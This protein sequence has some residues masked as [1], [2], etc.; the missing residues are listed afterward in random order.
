MGK[1]IAIE[2][3]GFLMES[4]KVFLCLSTLVGLRTRKRIIRILPIVLGVQ[5]IIL[6][7]FKLDNAPSNV[8]M[9]VHIILI[10]ILMLMCFRARFR[11]IIGIYI[12]CQAGISIMDVLI[13]LFIVRLPGLSADELLGDKVII[14]MIN[15]VSLMIILI[16]AMIQRRINKLILIPLKE[17]HWSYYLLIIWVLFFFTLMIGYLQLILEEDNNTLTN[18][19]LLV[20]SVVTFGII[21]I[22]IIMSR[23]AYNR[24][25][26][27]YL[28]KMNEE[29]LDIQQQYYLLL[30]QKNEDIKRF[31]HDIKNHFLCLRSITQEGDMTKVISYLNDLIPEIRDITEKVSTGSNVADAII[32]D[33]MTKY[34][35]VT[36]DVRGKLPNPLFIHAVDICT[37]FSNAIN[38]ALEAVLKFPAHADK[39]ISVQIKNW[40]NNIYITILNPVMKKPLIINNEIETTKPERSLHGFG[41]SNIKRCVAKYH[42]TIGLSS[43]DTEF[44]LELILKNENN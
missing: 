38:N 25:K 34:P 33:A 24:D 31:R 15:S 3:V 40:E 20:L 43:T 30:S 11:K 8:I 23:A 16:V 9:L 13:Y 36:I 35:E 14:L 5:L 29:Y 10:C 1:S 41:L 2:W 42:G 22:V 32:N 6:M 28:A 12:I 37:I 27:K 39:T 19:L 21:A 4:L 26:Y 18:I 17:I 44:T 7:L